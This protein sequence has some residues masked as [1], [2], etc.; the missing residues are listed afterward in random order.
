MLWWAERSYGL[1]LEDIGTGQVI[2]FR[3]EGDTGEDGEMTTLVLV[4][5]TS[6]DGGRV[7]VGDAVAF[8]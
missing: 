2:L 1:C 8:D 5:N 4:E 3:R 6:K 7:K